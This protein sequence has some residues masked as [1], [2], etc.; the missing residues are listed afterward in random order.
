MSV[1]APV[2][3]IQPRMREPTIGRPDTY[4][5]AVRPHS[6]KFAT[7]IC[8]STIVTGSASRPRSPDE[9][10]LVPPTENHAGPADYSA[11]LQS[12]L[13]P[14]TAPALLADLARRHTELRPLIAANPATDSELLEWLT[15]L[16]EPV[17]LAAIAARPRES[18]QQI[19]RPPVTA[20]LSAELTAASVATAS[21]EAPALIPTNAARVSNA[22]SEPGAQ[23]RRKRIVVVTAAAAAVLLVVG[24]GVFAASSFLTGGFSSATESAKAFPSTTYTWAEWAIDPSV[25][26][27]LGA[28]KV[29]ESL[30]AVKDLLKKS[31]PN[32]DYE[33]PDLKRS[34][35]TYL[36]D[37]VDFARHS[38]L[39]YQTDIQPWLGSRVAFGYVGSAPSVDKAIVVAI[40]ATNSDAGVKAVVSTL[41]DLQVTGMQVSA[42]NG[43][44]IVSSADLDMTKAYAAGTL[45]DTPAFKSAS[46]KLGSWGLATWWSSPRA[47]IEAN[48]AW[49]QQSAGAQG[50]LSQSYWDDYYRGD[51]TSW[52]QSVIDYNSTCPRNATFVSYYCRSSLAPTE[53]TFY[54]SYGYYPYAWE[55]E[56]AKSLKAAVSDNATVLASSRALINAVSA[57]GSIAGVLRVDGG[58]VELVA[59]TSN[60]RLPEF[61]NPQNA[62]AL[63]TLPASTIAAASVSKAGSLID[64]AFSPP[65]FAMGFAVEFGVSPSSSMDAF[66][67][68]VNYHGDSFPTLVASARKDFESS[69]ENTL[70]LRMPDQVAAA[71][72]TNA[73]VAV[74]KNFSCGIYDVSSRNGDCSKPRAG[75]L[76]YTDNVP[77]SADA[78][79]T[80]IASL[81]KSQETGIDITKGDGKV[82]V[83]R[84]SYGAELLKGNGELGLR[85]QFA[86]TVPDLGGASSAAFVDVKAVIAEVKSQQSHYS[87]SP[88]DGLK[89]FDGIS[90]AGYTATKSG[91]GDVTVRV[92]ILMSVK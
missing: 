13:D 72:G 19:P 34:I 6:S 35:W 77:D 66:R 25:N 44:V 89:Y 23:R 48:F 36:F 57:D 20:T 76:V 12:A 43:Y 11:R 37:N 56:A 45:A 61:G 27:K 29:L 50:T 63:A 54:D 18:E 60:I 16:G 73:I 28:V 15:G 90:T 53:K 41:K 8:E 1:A 86:E 33:K 75:A 87:G 62:A 68:L 79:D 71:L 32:I 39:S 5:C 58:T 51:F 49:A 88:I 4:Y 52:Q 74:D 3:R 31:G 9:R 47:A 65:Y 85:A 67:S 59:L 14:S 7:R 40:E 80:L 22:S 26:Q 17:V 55:A 70:G 46:A 82:A 83:S 78:L 21:H 38:S 64:T 69:I 42:R 92:R 84:G 10:R 30:P 2:L 91:N 81:N 24:G